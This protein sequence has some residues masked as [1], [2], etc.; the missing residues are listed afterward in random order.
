MII[1]QFNDRHNTPSFR[2]VVTTIERYD[3]RMRTLVN[4]RA[5]RHQLFSFP[6]I[7]GVIPLVSLC[8]IYTVSVGTPR[9]PVPSSRPGVKPSSDLVEVA[10][11]IYCRYVSFFSCSGNGYVDASRIPL[12]PKLNVPRHVDHIITPLA[13]SHG[14]DNGREQ[15]N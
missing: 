12:Q 14:S 4:R 2:M 8:T 5:V 3:H 1:H 11:K 7:L 6:C 13:A 10:S 9:L 15:T